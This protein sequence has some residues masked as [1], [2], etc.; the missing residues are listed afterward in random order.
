MGDQDKETVIIQ[1]V[2]GNQN[3]DWYNTV[4]LNIIWPV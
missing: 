2:L 1:W 4:L 3:H